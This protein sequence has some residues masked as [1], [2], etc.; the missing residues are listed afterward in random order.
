MKSNVELT[1][2]REK[3]KQD[4]FNKSY[5]LFMKEVEPYVIFNDTQ[6]IFLLI[7]LMIKFQDVHFAIQNIIQ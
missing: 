1:E 6:D 3:I 5:Q 2:V 4:K 7:Q